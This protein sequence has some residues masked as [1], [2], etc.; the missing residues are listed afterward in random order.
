MIYI[1]HLLGKK[2]CRELVLSQH[3]MKKV[4]CKVIKAVEPTKAT[5]MG[6]E[7]GRDAL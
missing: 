2:P 3:F 4:E 7:P 6:Y 5:S 1:F